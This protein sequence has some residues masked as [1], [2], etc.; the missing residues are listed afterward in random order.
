MSSILIAFDNPLSDSK[1]K[2][3]LDDLDIGLTC[4][5]TFEMIVKIIAKGFLFCGRHSY[6][7]QPWNIL[8][9]F[10]CFSSII[11]YFGSGKLHII[12]LFRLLRAIK[13]L[14]LIS[15]NEGL[16]LA[17]KTMMKAAPSLLQLMLILF[18]FFVLFG[19]FMVNVMK[20]S[21]HTCRL[22]G[23]GTLE[24]VIHKWDCL[25]F[26]GVWDMSQRHFDRFLTSIQSFYDITIGHTQRLVWTMADHVSMDMQPKRDFNSK[27]LVPLFLYNLLFGC[28]FSSL[29]I[30]VVVNTFDDVRIIYGQYDKL[31]EHQKRW[32]T[33]K[34]TM[35]NSTAP[36]RKCESKSEWTKLC[37]RIKNHFLFRFAKNGLLIAYTALL[38]T[39]DPTE[40]KQLQSRNYENRLILLAFFLV[41]FL[42][43]FKAFRGQYLRDNWNRF[44][45]TMYIL[46]L[47]GYIMGETS[48]D[49]LESLSRVLICAS[50]VRLIR[51]SKGS[52]MMRILIDTFVISMPSILNVGSLLLLIIYIYAILGMQLFARVNL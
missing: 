26:G 20:G 9:L 16:R 42:I 43:C 31:T 27:W 8:D 44:D 24:E 50:S 15:R 40:G 14:R 29:Y 30:G 34:K 11:S 4:V 47:V 6:F 5:F 12:K 1:I 7:R 32:I 41:E 3:V 37:F 48:R 19:I 46:T 21:F 25:N 10:I 35:I 18:I 28:F 33:M 23:V 36:I 22:Q 2:K 39:R 51:T 17:L 45:F 52:K 49:F 38:V 13:P